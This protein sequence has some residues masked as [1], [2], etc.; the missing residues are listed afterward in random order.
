MGNREKERDEKVKCKK[1]MSKKKKTKLLLF[2]N[3]YQ[4]L[5]EES[6]HSQIKRLK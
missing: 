5:I 4:I 2:L 3:P 1:K 6:W